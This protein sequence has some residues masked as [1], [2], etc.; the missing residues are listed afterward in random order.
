MMII[1]TTFLF[2]SSASLLLMY[3]PSIHMR[4]ALV[5]ACMHTLSAC[6]QQAEDANSQ[7][8]KLRRRM[9][10]H[11]RRCRK[12]KEEISELLKLLIL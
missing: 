10:G 8:S 6:R 7:Q 3:S 1:N 5:G 9:Q 2:S 12:Y 11:E 4:P